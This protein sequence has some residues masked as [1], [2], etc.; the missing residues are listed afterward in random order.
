MAYKIILIFLFSAFILN[1]QVNTEKMRK[2]DISNG[3][4][5]KIAAEVALKSG[6]EEYMKIASNFRTDYVKNN[7]LT[8][9]V[10]NIEYKEGNNAIITNKGFLH[11]RSIY[12]V[13][14]FWDV[15]AFTQAEYNEFI[16]M[17][18]RYLGG[19]G[20]RLEPVNI[21]YGEDKKSLF[22]LHIGIGV[23]YEYEH[24]GNAETSKIFR[25]IRST[26]NI[27]LL[28]KI[29]DV[30]SISEIVYFQ[31]DLE[32]FDDFRILNDLALT[33]KV[34][35]N[36]SFYINMNYRFD[37]DPFLEIGNYDFALTNG[38]EVRF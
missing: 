19:S 22:A 6:N 28:W 37:S 10:G 9:L 34:F 13:N 36:V 23:M 16:E 21:F 30:F 38:I 33:F 12:S 15:E 27:N 29:N 32:N 4:F 1:S 8:F 26:N 17:K 2:D 18:E 5:N 14:H 24:Q 31:P 7:F 3:W 35:E 20:I 25:L 11:L